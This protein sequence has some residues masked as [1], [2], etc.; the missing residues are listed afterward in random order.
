MS[1]HLVLGAL[2][3]SVSACTTLGPMP[4][5]TGLSATPIGR[6]GMQIQA[7][8]V[9]G[10]YASKS[11]QNKAEAEPIKQL[12]ALADL[13]HWLGVPG[14]IFGVRV[15]GE[16]GDA[17]GEAF[18]GYRKKLGTVSISGVAFG[19]TKRSEKQLASYHGTRLGAEGAV[20]AELAHNSWLGVHAQAAVTATY[21]SLSGTY[22]VNSTGIAVDCSPDEPQSNTTVTGDDKGV[23]PAATGQLAVDLGPHH[24]VFDNARLALLGTAGTMPLIV[25]GA[26]RETAAYLMLGATLSVA[27]GFER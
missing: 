27:F 10:Y 23:Y 7:G 1:N 25:D 19:S 9:P 16:S 18:V 3:A 21:S 20:E 6:P 14:L 13:D 24:G 15:F 2:L 22:C 5:T 17:P 4:A 11:V 12:S 26:K 8:A